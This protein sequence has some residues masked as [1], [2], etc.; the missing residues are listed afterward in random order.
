MLTLLL[1]LL[2]VGVLLSVPAPSSFCTSKASSCLAL[3]P[4]LSLPLRPHLSR[5]AVL[6]RCLHHCCTAVPPLPPLF[7]LFPALLLPLLQHLPLAA[8]PARVAST[9][10]SCDSTD[11]SIASQL[12]PPVPPPL[13]LV[14]PPT[15]QLPPLLPSLLLLLPPVLLPPPV[16]LH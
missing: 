10:Y 4:D 11:H 7:L 2:L 6:L 9:M 14:L 16:L 1:L 13:P 8:P 5:W 12:S 15:L 3:L